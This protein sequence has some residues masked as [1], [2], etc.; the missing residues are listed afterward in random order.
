MN[1]MAKKIAP[2]MA[3][4]LIAHDDTKQMGEILSQWDYRDD[5]DKA[6]PTIFQAVYRKFAL[7]VF[8]DELGKDLART[9]LGHRSFWNERLGRMVLNGTSHWFDNVNTNNTKETMDELFHQ[10]ALNVAETFGESLGKDLN[11]WAWGKVHQLELV[12]PIRR[13]GFGK[14][15]VGGGSHPFRGSGETLCRS[16]YDFNDPFGVT[17]SASLR[18]VADLGDNDKVLAV[19][20]GGVSG[21]L[22]YPHTKDQIEAYIDGSKVYWWLSDEAIKKHAKTTLVLKP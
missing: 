15:L 3:K 7:L 11:K 14:G 13:K 22:F 19:L 17:V 12:S 4:A 8:Q 20:P 16:N 21:R 1:L 9:M 10:A 6:A 18:M 2:I 5:I